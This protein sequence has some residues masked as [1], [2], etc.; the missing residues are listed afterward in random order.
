MSWF[1]AYRA[2]D[3]DTLA[4][5]ANAVLV[6]RAA[7][8]VEADKLA[9]I[10]QR[11]DGGTISTDGQCVQLDARG[12]KHARCDCPA[13]DICKHI[14]GA[15]LWLRAAPPSSTATSAK[16]EPDSVED[17]KQVQAPP[18]KPSAL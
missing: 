10:E 11:D 9:W 7:K 3:D 13:P 5:L 12:P 16:T 1:E 15:V 2:Y 4:A 18:S 6:S 14:L 8:D 17:D